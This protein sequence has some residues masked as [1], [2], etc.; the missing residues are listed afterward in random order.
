[1]LLV[2]MP[3]SIKNRGIADNKGKGSQS[4]PFFQGEVILLKFKRIYDFK[5][6]IKT[7]K[8]KTDYQ[9]VPKAYLVL[10]ASP[11]WVELV[12]HTLKHDRCHWYVSDRRTGCRLRR[13]AVGSRFKEIAVQNVLSWLGCIRESYY[14]ECVNLVSRKTH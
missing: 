9:S 4:F 3:V 2:L 7:C 12:V 1:M 5:I 11:E 13:Q 8:G 6:R 10:G 14:T